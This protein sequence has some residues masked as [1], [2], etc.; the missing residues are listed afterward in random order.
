MLIFV[1]GKGHP[2]QKNWRQAVECCLSTFDE[3]SLLLTK[4]CGKV[5]DDLK[6]FLTP[7]MR[8]VN[9]EPFKKNSCDLLL[10]GLLVGLGKEVEQ[11]AREVVRVAVW[12]SKLKRKMN[13]ISRLL[14]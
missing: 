3:C 11:G 8:T 10:N 9:Y 12:V 5:F 7:R 1:C 2:K 13:K 4:C 14:S 6:H